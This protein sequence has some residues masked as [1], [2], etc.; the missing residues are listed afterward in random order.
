MVNRPTRNISTVMGLLALLAL[1]IWAAL[2]GSG[3]V[4]DASDSPVNTITSLTPPMATVNLGGQVTTTA[5]VV[6][7]ETT[8]LQA[9][10]LSGPVPRD[11][12]FSLTPAAPCGTG[13][14]TVTVTIRVGTGTAPGQYIV[15][16]SAYRSNETAPIDTRVFPLIVMQGT[17]TPTLVPPTP[18]IPTPTA[19]PTTTPTPTAT[20]TR[21]PTPTPT[22]RPTR[23]IPPTA[24]PTPAPAVWRDRPPGNAG[25]L[26]TCPSSGEWLQLYWDSATATPIEQAVKACPNADRYWTSREGRWLGFTRGETNANDSWDVLPGEV[27]LVHG[28]QPT[29]R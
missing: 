8:C 9:A 4:V 13:N 27:C 19:T 29:K 2:A 5:S 1:A 26:R 15:T 20:P 17:A 28:G 22:A 6:V 11:I 12:T 16:V 3:P 25:A 23:T 24:T 10:V 18:P 7:T 14:Y 21:T